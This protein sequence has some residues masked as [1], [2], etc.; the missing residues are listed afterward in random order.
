MPAESDDEAERPARHARKTRL[1][2]LSSIHWN[3]YR[4]HAVAFTFVPL[5]A[6]GIFYGSNGRYHI[7]YIDSL[8]LCTSA[9]SVTGLATIN[10]SEATGWQQAMLVCLVVH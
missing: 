8:F 3:F 4:L 2:L 6:S 5:I 9:M 7:S 1:P 10:I